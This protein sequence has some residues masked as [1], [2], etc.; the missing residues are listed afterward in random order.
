MINAMN[1]DV[2]RL[3]RLVESML[4][5]I[6]T[7]ATHIDFKLVDLS[8]LLS[9]LVSQMQALADE[10]QI[11]LTLELPANAQTTGDPDQLVQLFLNLLHNA[12]KYTDKCGQVHVR[13]LLHDA[14]WQIEVDDTGIGIAAEHLP[15]LFERFYRADSSRTRLTG[16]IG[17]GLAI[18]QAIVRQH[19]GRIVVQSQVGRGSTFSVFLP[20]T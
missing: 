1:G 17:L 12:L 18:A 13:G 16:G 15:D 7:E 9:G 6:R 19:G 10:K 4:T 11:S 20:S 3:T 8:E 5:L 14:E 2:D